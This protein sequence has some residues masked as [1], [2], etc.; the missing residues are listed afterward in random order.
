MKSIVYRY[1]LISGALLVFF[2]FSSALVWGNDLDYVMATI[3]GYM[4][5]MISMVPVFLGIK[6]VRNDH[7]HGFISLQDALK[8]GL[9]IVLIASLIYV[10]GWM[11]FYQMIGADFME[12]NHE[13][14][15]T[16]L[17]KTKLPQEEID[18]QIENLKQQQAKY[19]NLFMRIGYAFADI[20]P[21]GIIIALLSS[22]YLMRKRH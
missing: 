20:L 16:E 6:K 9:G 14:M 15:I 17:N 4:T 18:V 3:I 5:L 1:G 19:G 2:M 11:L 8:A 12:H 22:L 13:Q 21:P 7:F 10:M